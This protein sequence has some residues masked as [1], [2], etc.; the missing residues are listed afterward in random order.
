[1]AKSR[2]QADDAPE[3]GKLIR[4]SIYRRF[5][6]RGLVAL[7]IAGLALTIWMRW[8]DV[9]TL[10]VSPVL[11][12]MSPKSRCPADP[13]RFSVLVA[14]LES[15]P[16]DQ[17]LIIITEAM[18]RDFPAVQV[19]LLDRTIAVEGAIPEETER[20]GHEEARRYLKESGA[21]VLI[22]GTVLHYGGDA[23]DKLYMTATGIEPGAPHQ[24][25]PEVASEFRLPAIFWAQLAD[26]LRL[27]VASQN[28]QFDAQS[29]QYVSDRLPAFISQVERLLETSAARPDWSPQDRGAVRTVLGDAL[30]RLGEQAGT[31]EPLRQAVDAY[32]EALQELTR[33][34]DALGWVRAQNGL[35]RAL[36]VLGQREGD[37]V[38]LEQ[39]IAAHQA[40]LT[41]LTREHA[42]LDWAGTQNLLGGALGTLDQQQPD[43]ARLQQAIAAFEAAAEEWTRERVPL[44][45]AT[46]QSNLGK[47]LAQLGGRDASAAPLLRAVA[48]IQAALQEWTRE[49][50]PLDWAAAQFD[51]GETLDSAWRARRRQRAV[52]AGP[53]GLSGRVAGTD[54]RAR[55]PRLGQGPGRPGQGLVQARR[56]RRRHGAPAAGSG[57]PRGRLAKTDPR[58]RPARLGCGAE[59]SGPRPPRAGHARGR[60][61]PP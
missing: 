16:D 35:G 18:G 6:L 29:G 33:E 15:D 14:H 21:S 51:L 26:V 59:Q 4:Q 57:G 39:A 22:W 58:A 46:V 40:A 3:I 55:A 54:A 30:Q 19:L 52:R 12:P 38:L 27:L 7:A 42:P 37:R 61:G 1:M 24:Y 25:T 11:S 13:N 43:T 53:G 47:A 5:G 23:K 9:R 8:N 44:K 10:P 34:R 49:R 56:T 28:A 31:N 50:A 41:Q 36:T 32:R 2:K 60:P 20:R 48:A 17:N 45:W